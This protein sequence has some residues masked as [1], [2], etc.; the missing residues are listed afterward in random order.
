MQKVKKLGILLALTASLAL[1]GCGSSRGDN[2]VVSMRLAHNMSEDHPVHKSLTEFVRLVE[3]KSEGSIDIEIYPNGVLGSE[4]ETIE[5][6]QTGAIDIAKV[7][8]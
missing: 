7:S 2:D 5:L 8:T 4:R 1:V 3:E 6:T